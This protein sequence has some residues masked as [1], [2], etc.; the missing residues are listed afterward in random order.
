MTPE[1]RQKNQ[2]IGIKEVLSN[3]LVLRVAMS[4]NNM[5]YVV[6]V[7][8]GYD[9]KHFYFHSKMNGKKID[10]LTRN[11]AVCFELDYGVELMPHEEA[12]HWDVRYRSVIG[13]GTARLLTEADEKKKGFDAIMQKYAGNGNFE[14]NEKQFSHAALVQITISE[15]NFK[16]SGD[17][18]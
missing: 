4:D 11:P 9:G 16:E 7:N 1:E 17:W 13:Y 14:Y 10:I 12:C 6:P 3:A 2:E 18:G 8:F 15:M 5:P